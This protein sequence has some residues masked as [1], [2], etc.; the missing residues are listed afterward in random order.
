[1][2]KKVLIV[3]SVVKTH[4]M[5]F[6]IPTLKMLKEMGYEV[7]VCAKNDYR[8][9]AE[10][11]VPF[12]DKYINIGFNRTPLSIKNYKSYNQLKKLMLNEQYDI[13][14]CHTPVPSALTRLAIKNFKHKPKVIYT[15]HGF[16]FYKG[17]PIKNWLIFYPIEM[18][19]SKYTDVLIIINQEDYSIVKT[20]FKAKEIRLVNGVGVDVDKFKSLSNAEKNK[21]REKLG[22]DNDDF[23][24]VYVAELVRNKRQ[25]DLIRAVQQ[26]NNIKIKLLLIGQG[27]EHSNY[28]EYIENNNLDNQVE[29]LGYQNNINEWLN[30]TD[31]YISPSEREGLPVNIL[32]ALAVGLP[33]LASNCRG[34]R[35]LISEEYLF[36][37]GDIQGLEKLI[38][39]SITNT[40]D[41]T[42]KIDIKNYTSNS[43]LNR[44]R[45][46]YGS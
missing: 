33:V 15:A 20:K 44:L 13:V 24:I 18:Y 12:C 21:L 14:H 41:Y 42:S 28:S 7:H 5:Q 37:V 3:A 26:V 45:S 16:H 25:L 32:E 30:I 2:S 46:F 29:L 31:L 39:E 34:N 35:D 17:A 9:A 19:L 11:Q 1:M 10:C 8:N 22:F 38:N 36:E 27:I 4:I 23:I 43:F 40:Q 6:H